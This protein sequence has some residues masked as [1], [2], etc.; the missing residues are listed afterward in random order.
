MQGRQRMR[1]PMV[2]NCPCCDGAAEVVKEAGWIAR[3]TAC[4]L[5]SEEHA[6]PE[7][8]AEAWNRRAASG[9]RVLSLRELSDSLWSYMDA[10][11]RAAVWIEKREGGVQAAI[12]ETGNDFGAYTL[13][14]LTAGGAWLDIPAGA[15]QRLGETWRIWDRLPNA[16]ERAAAEW[17][18]AD[19][20]G[21]TGE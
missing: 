11:G 7:S 21:G 8:A 9:A 2:K 10:E 1:P 12:V 16:R 19:H 3:C 4:G 18:N 13:R 20:E 17:T 6:W 5:R 14:V 15:I